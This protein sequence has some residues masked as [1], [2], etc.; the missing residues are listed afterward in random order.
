[1]TAGWSASTTVSAGAAHHARQIHCQSSWQSNPGCK[2]VLVLVLVQE[3]G[4]L[5]HAAIASGAKRIEVLPVWCGHAHTGC[6]RK[7]HMHLQDGVL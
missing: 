2:G 7:H 1:M 3:G 5:A 6:C 4:G